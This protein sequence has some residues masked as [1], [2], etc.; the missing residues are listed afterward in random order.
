MSRAFG[1]GER[2]S[3][4]G[5]SENQNRTL[6]NGQALALQIGGRFISKQGL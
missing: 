2:I 5:T 4:H 6:L 1:E 3:I